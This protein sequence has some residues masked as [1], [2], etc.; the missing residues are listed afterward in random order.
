MIFNQIF[1][2][3]IRLCN[4]CIYALLTPL[5]PRRLHSKLC[6]YINVFVNVMVGFIEVHKKVSEDKGWHLSIVFFMVLLCQMGG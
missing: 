4:T 5:P 2:L 6:I 1:W 3:K